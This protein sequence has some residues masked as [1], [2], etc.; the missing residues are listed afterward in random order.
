MEIFMQDTKKKVNEHW[1]MIIREIKKRHI[2]FDAEAAL[3][4]IGLAEVTRNNTTF[5]NNDLVW[6][7]K[8]NRNKYD[9]YFGPYFTGQYLTIREKQVL[10][11]VVNH[12][13]KDIGDILSLSKRTIEAYVNKIKHKFFC[14]TKKELVNFIDENNIL[15]YISDYD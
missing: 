9:I 3:Q 11:Y 2:N 5:I 12:T 1:D 7:L 10:V 15:S 8:V 13:Y 4:A 6:N 14:K